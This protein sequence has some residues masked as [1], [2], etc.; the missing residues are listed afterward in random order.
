[1]FAL[2]DLGG[3]N[4]VSFLPLSILASDWRDLV[5]G[6]VSTY[7]FSNRPFSIFGLS[8]ASQGKNYLSGD[9]EALEHSESFFNSVSDVPMHEKL[10]SQPYSPLIALMTADYLFRARDLP[11]WGG[12]FPEIDMKTVINKSIKEL[13]HGLYSNHRVLR[14][15]EI[16]NKIALK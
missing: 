13:A 15:L 11:G 9:K 16:L 5:A 10:A 3:S 8:K 7:A 2:S 12:D 14:E 1:M 4:I 6:E